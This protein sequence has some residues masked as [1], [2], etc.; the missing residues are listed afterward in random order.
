MKFLHR[1]RLKGRNYKTAE[2]LNN[3][4]YLYVSMNNKYFP[5]EQIGFNDLYF[6]CYMIE[7]VTRRLHYEPSYVQSRAF[8]NGGF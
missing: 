7:R 1:S 5:D 2:Y 8:I 4:L 6:V 3:L